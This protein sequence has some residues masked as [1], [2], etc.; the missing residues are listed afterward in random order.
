[1]QKF[2]VSKELFED[3]LLKKELILRRENNKYWKKVLFEPKII[4]DKIEYPIKQFDTLTITNGLGKDVPLL[5]IECKKVEYSNSNDCFEFF[6]GKVI[7]QKNTNLEEDYKDNL[8]EELLREKEL[9]KD[10]IN[11]DSLTK[12][13]NRRKMEYD[14]EIFSRQSNSSFLS[15]IS[16]TINRF[17]RINK[18]YGRQIGDNVVINLSQILEKYA[19][20]LNGEL[21]RY[22]EDEFLFLCFTQKN[23]IEESLNLLIKEVKEK[24]IYHNLEEISIIINIGICFLS[25]S[26]NTN[27]MIEES[28]NAA[29]KAINKG[30]YKIEFA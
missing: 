7:E 6:L 1:M 27:E 8:I 18:E 4:N 10:Q 22:S 9:L 26:V 21:Y 3:I 5:V 11:R 12:V 23:H 30:R 2:S 17:H 19:N 15:S 25:Q 20:I 28:N 29:L 24:K 16:I 14:L 13:Y